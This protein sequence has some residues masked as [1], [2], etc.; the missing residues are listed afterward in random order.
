MNRRQVVDHVIEK[1]TLAAGENHP[2][3]H[4]SWETEMN[5]VKQKRGVDFGYL[6]HFWDMIFATKFWIVNFVD[7][8]FMPKSIIL[9]LIRLWTL[10]I[11]SWQLFWVLSCLRSLCPY[12]KFTWPCTPIST[13]KSLITSQYAKL[14]SQSHNPENNAPIF[15]YPNLKM[16]GRHRFPQTTFAGKI[17]IILAADGFNING[18]PQ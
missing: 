13:E 12:G 8:S 1:P 16:R 10:N 15:P 7:M 5:K 11:I 17:I 4:P 14:S 2:A 3:W 9:N 6:G 18:K